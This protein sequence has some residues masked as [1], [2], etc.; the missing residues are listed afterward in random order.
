MHE[1]YQDY[2]A[3]VHPSFKEGLPNAICEALAAGLPVLAGDVCDHP[4]LIQDG[5]NGWLFDPGDPQS[6]ADA[7]LNFSRQSDTERV[8]MSTEARRTAE[9]SLSMDMLVDEYVRVLYDICP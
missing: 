1:V 2:D 9:T 7:L 5:I 6:I 8:E 4:L 3:L